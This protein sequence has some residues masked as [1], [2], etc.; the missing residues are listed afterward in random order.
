MDDRGLLK[1]GGS[2]VRVGQDGSRI[3]RRVRGGTV[4][5]ASTRQSVDWSVNVTMIRR[6]KR[7]LCTPSV[8]Q[9]DRSDD[10]NQH[11]D[12]HHEDVCETSQVQEDRTWRKQGAGTVGH[13]TQGL[14]GNLHTVKKKLYYIC[15][16]L[17][18][19]FYTCKSWWYTASRSL[20]PW[21]SC[22]HR[23][24]LRMLCSRRSRPT[25]SYREQCQSKSSLLLEKNRGRS[26][27]AVASVIV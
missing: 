1:V 5:A 16:F 2:G 7:R 13:D 8:Y 10:S 4:D 21:Q 14:R 17:N 9:F 19:I 3:H 15:F 27:K 18:Y 23:W 11:T 24:K 22:I 26:F 20:V 6:E 25:K 12:D